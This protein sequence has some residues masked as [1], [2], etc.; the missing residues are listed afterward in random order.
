MTE[1]RKHIC[2]TCKHWGIVNYCKLKKKKRYHS[3]SC[4][5]WEDAL[6]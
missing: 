5:K 1:K 6:K 2:F 4:K 3:S